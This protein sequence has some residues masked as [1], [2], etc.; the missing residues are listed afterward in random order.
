LCHSRYWQPM[1]ERDLVSSN[2][3]LE[4]AERGSLGPVRKGERQCRV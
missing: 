1:F 2:A 3:Q 4:S